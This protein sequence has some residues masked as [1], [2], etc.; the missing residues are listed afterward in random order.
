MTLA[1]TTRQTVAVSDGDASVLNVTA[2]TVIK[3]VPG[4]TY[5]VLVVTA[6]SAAGAL[7]DCATTG[8]VAAGNQVASIPDTV[9][10]YAFN[11]PHAVG[12]VLVPGTDQVLAIS[13]S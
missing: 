11:W 2:A 8:A 12:I 6:G 7:Y 10:A 1:P 3:A 5:R 4:R 9:G 13:F